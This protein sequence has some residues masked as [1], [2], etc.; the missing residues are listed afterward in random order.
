MIIYLFDLSARIECY[1]CT[2]SCSFVLLVDYQMNSNYSIDETNQPWS[3]SSK[4][5]H[6]VDLVS[7]FLKSS[8]TV[9]EER[10]SISK[11]PLSTAQSW[12]DI[13]QST[14]STTA[15]K[16][17]PVHSRASVS[18]AS[19]G[20]LTLP[21]TRASAEK[22]VYIGVDFQA[23]LAER[24]HSTNHKSHRRGSHTH[25]QQRR[26][27]PVNSSDVTTEN[28]PNKFVESQTSTR[29]SASVDELQQNSRIKPTKSRSNPRQ[30][31][32]IGDTPPKVPKSRQPKRGHAQEQ[33]AKN[34]SHSTSNIPS[35]NRPRETSL[36]QI[37]PS[38]SH[39]QP[40]VSRSQK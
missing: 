15:R 28:Q 1:V 22:P 36:P 9:V 17:I 30:Q 27:I 14:S 11:K 19:S 35:S 18:R 29:I 33:R 21:T 16:S 23:T 32:P 24:S 5:H 8:P 6:S 39:S 34:L 37:P 38:S 2:V 7:K 31:L 40:Q 12:H 20:T 13:F 3:T 4:A 25:Q 10:S 26:S